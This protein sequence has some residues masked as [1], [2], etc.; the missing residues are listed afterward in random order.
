MASKTTL[1]TFLLLFLLSNYANAQH[2]IAPGFDPREYISLLSLGF[3]G[4]SIA[5]SNDRKIQQDI[6]T[7]KYTS[8]EV[9]LKNKWWLYQRNDGVAVIFIRGTIGDKVSWAANFY[10]AMIP[11]KGVL[12][13]N[14]STDFKYKF[15]D[16]DKASVHVGWTVSLASMAADMILQIKQLY[17]NGTRDIY[18]V[19]HS[20]GGAIA[21]LASSYIHYLQQDG[22]LPKDILFKTYC[23]AAPKPGNMYYAYDFEFINRGGWAYTVVNRAD[24]VPEAPY[25]IQRIQDMNEL[26]PLV[27]AKD[28]L[29]KQKFAFRLVGGVLYGKLNNKPRRAQKMYVKYL[30]HAVFKRVVSKQLPQ[31]VEPHYIASSNYMRAGCPIILMPDTAYWQRFKDSGKDY[32]LH[33]HFEPYYYLLKKQYLK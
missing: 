21:F 9:G 22:E 7:K 4:N 5:D 6:Y 1:I 13:L 3:F 25:T 12:H 16:D 23:S 32:F 15:S 8:P 24:W 14:D 31:F 28:L 20:Q 33:H 29:K 26:N 27:H 30:G 2:K 17:A 10:A 11:A 19:G 18:I